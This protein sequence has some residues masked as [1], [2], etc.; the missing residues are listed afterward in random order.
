ME[1]TP[2]PDGD[3]ATLVAEFQGREGR[4]NSRLWEENQ[5]MLYLRNGEP[6]YPCS[7]GE[8]MGETDLHRDLMIDLIE[9]LKHH[10][11]AQDKVYVSGNILLYYEEGNP[12]VHIS[13]DVLVTLGIPKGPREIY[14]LWAE[15][16]APDFVI[17]VTSK[18]TR[19]RDVGVKK[20]LYEALGVKEYL[21]FD[22]RAEYLDPRFQVFRRE[23]KHFMPVLVPENRGYNSPLLGLTFRVVDEELRIFENVSGRMLLNPAEQVRR[24]RQEAQRAEQESQRAE[25]ESQRA[26]Q[27]S[28]RAE[29]EAE[30]A[31]RYADKLRELGIDPEAL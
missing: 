25:Q 17:E 8:P 7:D 3:S 5:D 4:G 16:K 23:G 30:R 2:G 6:D 13:P 26:E 21:L 20:G 10:F 15:G 11:E 24:A 27:E 22:P 1:R 9:A 12:L 31:R 18:S 14:K 28:Q 19:L 29:Q